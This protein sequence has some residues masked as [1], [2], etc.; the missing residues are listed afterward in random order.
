MDWA[1]VYVWLDEVDGLEVRGE[2][3]RTS[4]RNEL[5]RSD[6]VGADCHA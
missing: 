1:S 5:A 4:S 2:G 3:G 6:V